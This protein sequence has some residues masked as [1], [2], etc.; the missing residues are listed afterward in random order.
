MGVF[1]GAAKMENDQ[2][3]RFKKNIGY[4]ISHT[5]SNVFGNW[6][7]L[8]GLN[9]NHFLL[10]TPTYMATKKLNQSSLVLKAVVFKNN[11]FYDHS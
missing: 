7:G 8:S 2:E 6:H 1:V 4:A 11:A 10:Q 3:A 9:G 5:S